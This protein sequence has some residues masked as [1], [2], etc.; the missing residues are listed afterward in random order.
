MTAG[1]GGLPCVWRSLQPLAAVLAADSEAGSGAE[2][3][4][5]KRHAVLEEFTNSGPG[6]TMFPRVVGSSLTPILDPRCFPL[7]VPGSRPPEYA[8]RGS[9]ETG[10][11]AGKDDAGDTQVS[12]LTLEL[13]FIGAPRQMIKSWTTLST[14]NDNHSQ[15]NRMFRNQG[16]PLRQDMPIEA[17]LVEFEQ[18]PDSCT[19]DLRGKE[20][21]EPGKEIPIDLK[22]FKD[23]MGRRP[24][25]FNRVIV[26][27]TEGKILNGTP[28]E[29]FPEN[30][31]F[32][33]DKDVVTLRYQAPAE[34]GVTEDT[35]W[36]RDASE[37][38]PD[39]V[40]PLGQVQELGREI[41]KRKIPIRQG[42]SAWLKVSCQEQI[43]IDNAARMP[44][45]GPREKTQSTVKTEFTM[46]LSLGS[47]PDP[48][49][50]HGNH[51][52]YRVQSSG[53]SGTRVTKD[54][55][56]KQESGLPEH[57]EEREEYTTHLD[58]TPGRDT[59]PKQEGIVTLHVDRTTGRPYAV[60]IPF[61]GFAATWDGRKDC[62]GVRRSSVG[63]ALVPFDCSHDLHMNGRL[64]EG[65]V[66]ADDEC[67][68]V[69]GGPGSGPLR[70]GCTRTFKGSG[71]TSQASYQWEVDAH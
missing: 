13:W 50:T 31:V 24:R 42:S 34:A 61:L 6:E 32:L 52:G 62:K 25:P 29:K 5:C 47:K 38:L 28:W 15:Y 63:D 64:N 36:V 46:I 53:F 65:C 44:K 27:V 12:R 37:I 9:L 57:I 59:G 39:T 19:I 26:G 49:G 16:S 66:S 51:V 35:L 2:C 21:V 22:E 58:A 45:W 3:F 41:A 30:K 8:F 60:H 20:I 55:T 69:Q 23:T 18:P 17:L 43:D 1:E 48:A 4:R 14:L 70:G 56:G 33:L 7:V 67:W 54:V 10:I 40:V 68:K 11:D 71:K